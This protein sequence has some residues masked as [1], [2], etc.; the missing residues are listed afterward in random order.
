[1]GKV[2]DDDEIKKQIQEVWEMIEAE[3]KCPY[4]DEDGFTEIGAYA[5]WVLGIK[6]DELFK[7]CDELQKKA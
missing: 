5:E 3:P 7:P 4:A 2:L 6:M 1:M